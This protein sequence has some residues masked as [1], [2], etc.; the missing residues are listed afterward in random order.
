MGIISSQTRM[1]RRAAKDLVEI[2]YYDHAHIT[3]ENMREDLALYDR[4]VPNNRVKKL[5]VLGRHTKI[6]LDVR[7][8]AAEENRKR[9]SRIIAEAVVARSTAIRLAV[10]MYIL[11]LNKEFPV[12]VFSSTEKAAEW[13]RSIDD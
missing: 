11:F 8:W 7:K 6:D 3:L 4:L 9:K 5:I 13:L 10:N 2:V 12:K 1:I